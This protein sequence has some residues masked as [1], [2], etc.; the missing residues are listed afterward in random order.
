VLSGSLGVCA[1]PGLGVVLQK[2]GLSRWLW[3]SGL[4]KPRAGCGDCAGSIFLQALADHSR[5]NYLHLMN[6]AAEAEDRH[7]YFHYLKLA[8]KVL[9]NSKEE[10]GIWQPNRQPIG[11][12]GSSF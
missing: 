4:P 2:K 12:D 3:C 5:L 6:K 11:L 8:E 10:D 7:S 1:L 9:R